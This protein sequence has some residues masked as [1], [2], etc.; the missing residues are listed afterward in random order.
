MSSHAT[1]KSVVICCVG[2]EP[3]PL[4]LQVRPPAH[5]HAA[6]SKQVLSAHCG[7][8]R[9]HVDPWLQQSQGNSEQPAQRRQALSPAQLASEVQQVPLSTFTQLP[10]ASML[11]SVHGSKSLQRSAAAGSM[12]QQRSVQLLRQSSVSMSFPSSHCSPGSTLPSPQRG[13]AA[14]D[15]VPSTFVT[16]RLVDATFA[17]LV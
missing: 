15:V 1:P 12:T 4:S 13:A 9:M 10:L 3:G 8:L 5:S 6:S 16:T 11:S 2:V 14:A 7:E 17:F